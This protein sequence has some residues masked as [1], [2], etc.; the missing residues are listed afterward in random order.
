MGARRGSPGLSGRR[1]GAASSSC[2]QV[3]CRDNGVAA[4]AGGGGGGAGG[5]LARC[6]RTPE[7]GTQSRLK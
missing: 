6:R 2:A 3:T 1:A 5:T 4:H 7:E